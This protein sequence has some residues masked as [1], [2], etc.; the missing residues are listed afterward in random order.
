MGKN[1]R[2]RQLLDRYWEEQKV[3]S[4]DVQFIDLKVDPDNV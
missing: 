3:P 1:K 2:I 4:G